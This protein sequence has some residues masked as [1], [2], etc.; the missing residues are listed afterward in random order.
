M[1]CHI[2]II[3]DT[4]LNIMS[5]KL[6]L[7]AELNMDSNNIS[8]KVLILGPINS[9]KTQF[10]LNQLCGPLYDRPDYV[11]LICL[12]FAYNKI[13]FRFAYRNPRSFSSS[14]SSTRLAFG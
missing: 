3:A 13:L 5:R 4:Q 9:G 12:T 8:F 10:F 14:A 1:N 7:C 6:E 11:V 2:F